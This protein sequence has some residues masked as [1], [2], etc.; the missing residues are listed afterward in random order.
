MLTIHREKQPDQLI[1]MGQAPVLLQPEPKPEPVKEQVQA[2]PIE[3]PKNTRGRKK[4]ADKN[5]EEV[6]T[7]TIREDDPGTQGAIGSGGQNA[8]AQE[9][10]P[11]KP[12]DTDDKEG[13]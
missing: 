7:K 3:Q 11:D 12:Q 10:V 9:K 2:P 13:K 1:R 4:M 6:G 5:L 8:P